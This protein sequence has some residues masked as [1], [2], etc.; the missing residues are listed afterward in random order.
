MV[1]SVEEVLVEGPSKKNPEVL[2]ARTK[3]NKPVHAPGEY[4]P[5]SYLDVEIT[6]AASHHLLGRVVS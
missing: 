5:G 4:G 1:G 3:G 6:K 2:T